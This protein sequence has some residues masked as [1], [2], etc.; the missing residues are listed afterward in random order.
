MICDVALRT[1]MFLQTTIPRYQNGFILTSI[2]SFSVGGIGLTTDQGLEHDTGGPSHVFLKQKHKT[3]TV[4]SNYHDY[5]VPT[6]V[7][8]VIHK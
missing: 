4:I 6:A 8:L 2:K 1:A 7:Q 3:V 5:E